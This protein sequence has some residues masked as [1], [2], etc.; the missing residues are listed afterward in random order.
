MVFNKIKNFSAIL[1][2]FLFLYSCN[3]EENSSNNKIQETTNSDSLAQND[4]IVLR[5]KALA[6]SLDL[7][8]ANYEDLLKSKS[9]SD[10]RNKVFFRK[11]HLLQQENDSLKT[12]LN[13]MQ[14]EIPEI[15]DVPKEKIPSLSQDEKDIRSMIIS[16]NQAWITMHNTKKPKEVLRFFNYQFMVS[17][18][19]IEKDNSA[20]A[21]IY[22]HNDFGNFLREI[23]HKSE[24][25]FEF[26]DVSFFDIEV[27]DH[28]YFKAAFKCELRVYKGDIMQYKD[29]V[30]VT[31]AG[32]KIKNKWKIASYSW[33]GFKYNLKDSDNE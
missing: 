31:I 26:G 16:L 7:A 24:M 17:W 18:I 32:K 25:S 3:N 33:I 23:N 30:L 2:L 20:N 28:N 21:A 27:K 22:T 13:E 8:V 19:V 14:E 10:Y 6:D 29:S 4:S 1:F 12:I 5:M 11:L 9:G 15:V